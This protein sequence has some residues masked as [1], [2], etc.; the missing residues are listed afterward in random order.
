[1]SPV[2]DTDVALVE[3]TRLVRDK[4]AKLVENRVIKGDLLGQEKQLLEEY[5]AQVIVNATGLGAKELAH[6][7][8]VFP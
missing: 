1:I 3:I 4:G 2:L 6:D 7:K 5:S 8:N